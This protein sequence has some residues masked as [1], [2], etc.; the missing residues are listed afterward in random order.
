MAARPARRADAG[1]R[2]RER[3]TQVT[4]P[5]AL[6]LCSAAAAQVASSIECG[7]AKVE[8]PPKMHQVQPTA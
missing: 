2:S 4:A 8:A 7:D 1:S 6:S 3:A 5:A